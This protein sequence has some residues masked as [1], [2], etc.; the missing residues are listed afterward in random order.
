MSLHV[1]VNGI[2]S[3]QRP[4]WNK[5]KK[6]KTKKVQRVEA[7]E[8]M[9]GLIHCAGKGGR[10]VDEGMRRCGNGGKADEG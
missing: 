10:R 5:W 9:V 1:A 3:H 2:S 8:A 6:R 7:V 4:A